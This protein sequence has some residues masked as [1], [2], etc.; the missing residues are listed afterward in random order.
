MYTQREDIRPTLGRWASTSAVIA[1][2]FV[3]A[4][5]AIIALALAIGGPSESSDAWANLLGKSAAYLGVALALLAFLLAAASRIR[6]EPIESLWFPFSL[7][8]ILGA[9]ALLVYVF[10]V[11]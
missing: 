1:A 2:G 9:L 5:Y 8:P 3:P 11:R 10:W 6:R 4:A 7:F